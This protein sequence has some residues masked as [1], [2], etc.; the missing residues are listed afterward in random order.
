MEASNTYSESE[1]T[2]LDSENKSKKKSNFCEN[3]LMAFTYLLAIFIVVGSV[4]WFVYGIIF[5]V[6]DYHVAKDCSGSNLWAYILVAL[7]LY[8]NKINAKNIGDE[9]AIGLLICSAIVDFSLAIWGATELFDNSEGTGCDELEHSN[10]W[11]FGLATFI[12]QIIYSSLIILILLTVCLIS[13]Y[14]SSVTVSE[15]SPA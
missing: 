14:N 6:N 4:V 5:L 13:K 1:T 2:I 3:F 8:Y 7:I 9:E 12:I 15:L 11:K 10:L